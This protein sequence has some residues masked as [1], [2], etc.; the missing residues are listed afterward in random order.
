MRTV[1]AI[2]PLVLSLS[3]VVL[4]TGRPAGAQLDGQALY[5]EYCARCHGSDGLADTKQGKK[6][7]ASKLVDAKF[8][9]EG[10]TQEI[11]AGVRENKKHRIVSKK[12]TDEELQAI[13]EFVRSLNAG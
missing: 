6:V 9:A 10:A 8:A 2:V 1:L 4:A 12:V 13:A 3:V 11:V 5:E 7:K